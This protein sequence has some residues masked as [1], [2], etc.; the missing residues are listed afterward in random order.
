MRNELMRFAFCLSLLGKASPEEYA[1]RLRVTRN[2]LVY[3][4]DQI[5][6][7]SMPNLINDIYR[8]IHRNEI[9]ADFS[10][11]THQVNE[12]IGKRELLNGAP[13]LAPLV[14]RLDDHPLLQG[15]LALFAADDWA[16]APKLFKKRAE[17]F[18]QVFSQEILEDQE[19]LKTIGRGFLAIKDYG[20]KIH[21][22]HRY[23]YAI[24][25]PEVWSAIL[26]GVKWDDGFQTLRE[27]A[28]TFLDDLPSCPNRATVLARIGETAGERLAEMAENKE[29]TW[30]YYLA[31]Y[32]EMMAGGSGIIYGE[33]AYDAIMLTKFRLS[34]YCHAPYTWAVFQL[35][36]GGLAGL[37]KAERDELV[38]GLWFP[39][40]GDRTG[41]TVRGCGTLWN[42]DKGWALERPQGRTSY[43][44][45]EVREKFKIGD[46]NRLN[47]PQSKDGTDRK[48]RIKIGVKLVKAL[49]N[50]T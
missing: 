9:V 39:G 50:I 44:V 16:F 1:D 36:F 33:G 2:L 23:L 32:P 20:L 14:R 19:A 13:E 28:M 24:P 40:N 8:L 37:E 38:G 18:N 49:L 29:F 42:T 30:Q 46:D 3:S 10:F 22:D 21:W 34:S 47:I 27:T 25:D 7:G 5:K 41:A 12:E 26:T 48:D 17:T 15:K 43:H 31:Q 45:Q 6:A 4:D 35:A 11:N